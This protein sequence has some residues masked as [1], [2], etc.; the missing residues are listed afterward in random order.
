M[1]LTNVIVESVSAKQS[2]NDTMSSR[3]FFTK[4]KSCMSHLKHTRNTI[5]S[6]DSLQ[7]PSPPDPPN[8]DPVRKYLETLLQ[9]DYGYTN[10]S[11]FI[12]TFHTDT[13]DHQKLIEHVFN[14]LSRRSS[15]CPLPA[16]AETNEL[17]VAGSDTSD[18]S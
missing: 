9:S 11:D 1:S 12:V 5:W 18:S 15:V 8:T 6:A 16:I 2:E 3:P 17:E 4:V 14:T 13:E 7:A 10:P